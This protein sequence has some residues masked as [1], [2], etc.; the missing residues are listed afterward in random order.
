MSR[1]IGAIHAHPIETV[2]NLK[3]GIITVDS[4][5]EIAE[6]AAQSCSDMVSSCINTALITNG[7]A[8]KT[9]KLYNQMLSTSKNSMYVG[10]GR[11]EY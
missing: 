8:M 6:N 5:E 10:A 2:L 7:A 11:G 1:N 4:P 3:T 9:S